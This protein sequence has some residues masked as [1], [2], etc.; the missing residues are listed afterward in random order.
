M[1]RSMIV[2]GC[3]LMAVAMILTGFQTAEASWVRLDGM[4]LTGDQNIG[5]GTQTTS[6]YWMVQKDTSLIGINPAQ[7]MMF[8]QFAWV[9]TSEKGGINIKPMDN[10]AIYIIT[11]SGISSGFSQMTTT[12]YGE[13]GYVNNAY[14]GDLDESPSLDTRQIAA[15]LGYDLGNIKIGASFAYSSILEREKAEAGGASLKTKLKASETYIKGGANIDLGSGMDI[16]GALSATILSMD[17]SSNE[18]GVDQSYKST[19]SPM[20]GLVGRL[21]MDLSEKSKLHTYLRVDMLDYSTEAEEGTNSDTFDRKATLIVAGVSDEMKVNES[22]K[23]ILGGQIEYT[24]GTLDCSGKTGGVES[25]NDLSA[26]TTIIGVPVVFAV[27]SQIF[28]NWTA[29]FGGRY[30]I[31]NKNNV[32]GTVNLA[33]TDVDVTYTDKYDTSGAASMGLS[34]TLGKFLLEWNLNKDIF[35][36][37]PYLIGGIETGLS[38]DFMVVYQF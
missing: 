27:E 7:L 3:F 32:E 1:K 28:E 16:D 38:S 6:T 11:E 12:D 26:D 13:Y 24:M 14:V 4:S 9:T 22:A 15:T 5:S 18:T 34:W 33:G 20:F 10:L 8:G 29:R 36:N 25:P 17:N 19:G 2:L 37:G 23:V 30:N 31:Y 21:N 35:T